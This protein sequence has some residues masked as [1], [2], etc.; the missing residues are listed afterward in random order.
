MQARRTRKF[1]VGLLKKLKKRKQQRK[2]TAPSTTHGASSAS[3]GAP[4]ILFVSHE[5]TRT[6]APKIVL[7][8]LR[9]FHEKTDAHLQSILHSGGFLAEE[10]G[11]YSEV[12]CL[13]LPREPSDE[14]SRRVRKICTRHKDSPPTMAIC[15]SMESRFIAY[16]LQQL[17]IPVTFLVHEL[18]SSYEVIDYQQVY[19][20]SERVIFPVEVVRSAANEKV[21]NPGSKCLVMPQG[22][23]NPDF[24]SGINR[25]VVRRQI[26]HELN[27][28][29]DAFIVLGCGTLDLRKG[30]DHFCGV[31]RT[32]LRNRVH[33][34]PVHFVWLGE[35]DRW[36]HTPYHYAMLDVEK[37]GIFPHVHFIGEREDVQPWFMG[38]DVFSLTSRVDPFPCVIHEAMA[39]RLPIIAFDQSGGAVE[40]VS[41]GAGFVVPYADYDAMSERILLLANHP[42]IADN[43]RTVAQKKVHKEYR[44]DSYANRLIQ[45]AERT[46]RRRI[47]TTAMQLNTEIRQ[48][49]SSSVRRAA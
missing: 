33:K 44:F 45:M 11:L 20:C 47:S 23:L 43:V 30:I 48:S 36:A 40:C 17:G 24:A 8:I 32:L 19:D 7:N 41:G 38:A 35:G 16:E 6:G 29:Q 12:D 2:A 42:L 25:D 22:L 27:L 3:A 26:R 46:T 10:F 49:S 28:P 21:V 15:N 13:N 18:P 1:H 34:K 31:A 39:A 4:R 9:H 37:S 14:L 5:A